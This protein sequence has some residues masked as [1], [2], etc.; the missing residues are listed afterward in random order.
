MAEL[1]DE[2]S[3]LPDSPQC[4]A[5]IGQALVGVASW[6]PHEGQPPIPAHRLR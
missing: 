5:W 1:E 4:T 3:L 6:P 2:V